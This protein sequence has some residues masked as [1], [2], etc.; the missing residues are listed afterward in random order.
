M[1]TLTR[2]QW[3]I[4]AALT[5]SVMLVCICLVIGLVFLP[6]S[7]GPQST[8][9]ALETTNAALVAT[10][11]PPRLT[12]TPQPTA[13]QKSTSGSPPTWTPLPAI[14]P[15]AQSSSTKFTNDNW[16]LALT[17]ANSYKG[18][19]VLVYGKIFLDP[20]VSSDNIAFQMY[21]NSDA[22]SGNTIVVGPST[23]RVKQGDYVR[24]EG[25][26][27]DMFEGTN[28][29]G[30]TLSVP[31]IAAT[32]V[33]IVSREQVVAPATKTIAI[34][35]AINQSGL[36]ITLER[37]ELANQETRF[38]VKVENQSTEKA[39]VYTFDAALLQGTKQLKTKMIFDS[40]YPDLP[41]DMLPG[42]EAETVLVFDAVQ[43]SG[44]LKFIWDGPRLQNYSLN[45][46]PYQWD[47]SLK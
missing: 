20:Q 38:Y 40:G 16:G 3:V 14:A 44:S 9:V 8:D 13:I 46:K 6:G 47:V 34:T 29:F 21:T 7:T 28:A 30:A 45:F 5:A 43:P 39:S 12:A 31:R 4:L 35:K 41:S 2:T 25:K 33:D 19:S 18:A 1:T 42:V 32:K 10:K 36:V 24:V 22:T 17:G 15:S 26:I 23:L 11:L 37:V 27:Y